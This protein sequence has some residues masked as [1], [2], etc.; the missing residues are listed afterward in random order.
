MKLYKIPAGTDGYK[1]LPSPLIKIMEKTK[2]TREIICERGMSNTP[3]E[4]WL[5]ND[6]IIAQNT[7]N[8]HGDTIGHEMTRRGYATFVFIGSRG[9]QHTLFVPFRDVEVIC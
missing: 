7:G 2:T 8:I 4:C 5:V 9:E 3:G 1:L 6:P